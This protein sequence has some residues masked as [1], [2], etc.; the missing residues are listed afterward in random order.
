MQLIKR[1]FR[2]MITTQDLLKHTQFMV[3]YTC[4]IWN[5]TCFI[6]LWLKNTMFIP[7]EIDLHCRM[8]LHILISHWLEPFFTLLKITLFLECSCNCL[9]W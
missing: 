3:V 8:I 9:E 6:K 5:L 2:Q 1:S 7:K 4:N